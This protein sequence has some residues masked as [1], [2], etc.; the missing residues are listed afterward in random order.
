MEDF[1]GA[2]KATTTTLKPAKRMIPPEQLGEFRR[3]VQGSDLTKIALVEALKKK[4]V[5]PAR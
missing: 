2:F 5:T 3:E 4:Y 1:T